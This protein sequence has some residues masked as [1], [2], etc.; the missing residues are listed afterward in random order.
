MSDY[1]DRDGDDT[2]PLKKFEEKM[3]KY[4]PLIEE[5]IYRWFR[6]DLERCD[7]EMIRIYLLPDKEGEFQLLKKQRERLKEK[8]DT[9]VN[10]TLINF[11]SILHKLDEE[12]CFLVDEASLEEQIK[13][14]LST[15]AIR[16][17]LIEGAVLAPGEEI[18][19]K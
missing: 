16:L 9:W 13:T 7:K 14:Y 1:D 17:K 4:R 8:L 10:Q 12:G 5:T 6:E 15:T 18:Q 3:S 11:A 19:Y 2:Y